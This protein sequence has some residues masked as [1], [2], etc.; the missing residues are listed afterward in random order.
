MPPFISAPPTAPTVKGTEP[1]RI[2]PLLPSCGRFDSNH[3]L[4]FYLLQVYFK[5]MKRKKHFKNI[6]PNV[7]T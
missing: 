7:I 4:T 1:A 6:I 5:D 3:P 2:T